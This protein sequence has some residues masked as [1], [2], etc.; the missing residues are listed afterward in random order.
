MLAAG[1]AGRE[2][3]WTT[4]ETQACAVTLYAEICD[5]RGEPRF[6]RRFAAVDVQSFGWRGMKDE[7]L[8]AMAAGAV[9][10]AVDRMLADGELIGALR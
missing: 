5:A 6:A 7:K 2:T 3:S 1:G 10:R 9:K 4:V 8:A